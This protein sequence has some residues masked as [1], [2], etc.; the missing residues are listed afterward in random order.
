LTHYI[1]ANLTLV[2]WGQGGARG[3]AEIRQLILS[4]GG[5]RQRRAQGT[6]GE[7]A[8]D[9]RPESVAVSSMPA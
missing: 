2:G 7:R 3:V 4:N 1:S 6:D 9:A 8:L 5:K